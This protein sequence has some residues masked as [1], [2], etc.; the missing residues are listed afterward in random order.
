MFKLVTDKEQWPNW[1]LRA[2]ER[3]WDTPGSF[4]P[5]KGSIGY[6]RAVGFDG[7]SINYRLGDTIP[8]EL[9]KQEKKHDVR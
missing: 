5:V 4:Q 8:E 6:Y 7:R 9:F 3:E 2:W 1:L